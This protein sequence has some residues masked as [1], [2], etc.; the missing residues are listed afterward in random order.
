M[1][2]IVA[3]NTF[4]RVGIY[5]FGL[6]VIEL[7][8]KCL[9]KILVFGLLDEDRERNNTRVFIME[10]L[11]ARLSK[12]HH[13][14]GSD[15]VVTSSTGVP[16]AEAYDLAPRRTVICVLEHRCLF[17]VFPTCVPSNKVTATGGR[18]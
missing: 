18:I 9:S 8:L 4:W 5:I 16:E 14:P 12:V 7:F 3:A 6:L 15:G 17:Q 13:E 2:A 1:S 10:A 11:R